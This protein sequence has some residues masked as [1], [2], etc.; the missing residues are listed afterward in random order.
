MNTYELVG[1]RPSLPGGP[2]VNFAF[3]SGDTDTAIYIGAECKE[4]HYMAMVVTAQPVATVI[5]AI[6]QAWD[7][8]DL[9]IEYPV[10]ISI[11]VGL[12]P[13]RLTDAM[14]AYDCTIYLIV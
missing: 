5:P 12:T 1:V 13:R 3:Y 2:E 6:Q 8:F 9:G 10:T 11:T 14:Y 4:D 7:L